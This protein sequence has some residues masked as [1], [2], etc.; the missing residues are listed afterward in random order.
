MSLIKKD[1]K[2]AVILHTTFTRFEYAKKTIESFI[3][4]KR[5]VL[6][7]SDTG[8]ITPEKLDYYRELEKKGHYTFMTGWDTSPAITR[9][10]L[11]DNVEEDYIFKI[12]DDFEF[13]D[14]DVK[15]AEII[16]LLD[17]NQNL[18]LVGMS[19]VSAKVKSKFVFHAERLTDSKQGDFM[20]LDPIDLEKVKENIYCDVTPD[21]W[22][23]KR[24]IFPDCNW[25]ERY[26]VSEGLHTDFFLHIKFNTTWR[27]MY[28]PDSI[29]Y[30][31]KYDGKFDISENKGSF[32]NR[33]RFRKVK[34]LENFSRKWRLR[35][36]NPIN[37]W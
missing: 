21:C 13:N 17:E 24:E 26:H 29:M 31:F 15:V 32:Y 23:A 28:K 35:K 14:K 33:K 5:F 37:R 18:G 16:K 30:T 27:V 7:V 36:E 22:I 2:I 20:K 25:D 9:N 12:D 10:F 1:K 4:D 11:V 6:Y 34:N 3:K 19:V 8:A